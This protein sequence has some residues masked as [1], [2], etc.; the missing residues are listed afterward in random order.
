MSMGRYEE[1]T[2]RRKIKNEGCEGLRGIARDCEI[3]DFRR[4]FLFCFLP[5][6]IGSRGNGISLG[7]CLL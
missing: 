2:S 1:A 3:R 4:S 7:C 5:R 6:V